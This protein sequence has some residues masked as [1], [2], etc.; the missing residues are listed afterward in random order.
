ME[1]IESLDNFGPLITI[2]RRPHYNAC[3]MKNVLKPLNLNFAVPTKPA[4]HKINI[5]TRNENIRMRPNPI[6]K[7]EIRVK[8]WPKEWELLQPKFPFKEEG[9]RVLVSSL[10]SKENVFIDFG[11]MWHSKTL[12]Q[13]SEQQISTKW[14]HNLSC[15]SSILQVNVAEDE[16]C[17]MM[18]YCISNDEEWIFKS[19]IS[20]EMSESMNHIKSKSIALENMLVEEMSLVESN[21]FVIF[22]CAENYTLME[23]DAVMQNNVNETQSEQIL[24]P[25]IIQHI[26]FYESRHLGHFVT[27][28]DGTPIKTVPGLYEEHER[29]TKICKI[30]KPLEREQSIADIANT[31]ME[32]ILQ[33]LDGPDHSYARVHP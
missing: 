23:E 1:Y 33:G 32:D 11:K 4:S 9:P 19:I 26:I 7:I 22:S 30:I 6:Y 20:E 12:E 8:Y 31:I 28:G 24:I 5:P 13:E 2:I 29:D 21:D 16:E 17:S 14:R 25:E 10:N 3:D 27:V 18:K 15:K